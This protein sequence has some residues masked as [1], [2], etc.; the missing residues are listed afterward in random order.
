MSHPAQ[1]KKEWVVRTAESG[2]LKKKM[3]K[4]S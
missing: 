3:T 4:D 2:N 1:K